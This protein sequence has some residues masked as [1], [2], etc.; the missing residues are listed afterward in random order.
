MA[1]G[2]T[3]A[4]IR[5]EQHRRRVRAIHVALGR[6]GDDGGDDDGEAPR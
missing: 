6:D 5:E 3:G 1:A 4:Q 2:F